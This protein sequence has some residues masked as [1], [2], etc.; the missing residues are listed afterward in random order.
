MPELGRPLHPTIGP[1]TSDRIPAETARAPHAPSDAGLQEGGAT[2]AS[3]LPDAMF[4]GI[5]SIADDAIVSIDEAFRIVFFNRGAERIFG[6]IAE[7]VLGRELDLLIPVSLREVHR[8]HIGAFSAS[9]VDAR[10][11]GERS[12]IFGLRRNGER[13]PAEA[14]ISKLDVGGR[15]IY[16]ALLRDISE[17]KRAEAERQQLLARE[18]EARSAAEAAERRA[19]F[20]AEASAVL[21]SSLDFEA[22]LRSL[23]GLLVPGYADMCVVDLVTGRGVVQRVEVAHADPTRRELADRLRAYPDAH[24]WY[25]T[26]DAIR[27]GKPVLVAEVTDAPWRAHTEDAEHAELLR[28]LGISSYVAVPLVAR[29]H[30]LGALALCQG[31]AAQPYGP[32]DLA[33]AVAFARAAAL[34]VDNARLYRMEQRA[35]QA[36]DEVLGVVTHDLRNPL[37]VLSMCASSLL[38]GQHGAET[39]VR[40]TAETIRDA[41]AWALRLIQDLLDVAMIEAGHLAL[42]RRPQDAVILISKAAVMFE[43]MAEERS[44]RLVLD[45][46][47]QLP[48]VEA[49]GERVLQVLSNLIGNALKFTPAGGEIRLGA[50]AGEGQ[51]RISVADTGTGIPAEQLLHVF[52]R[53]WHARRGASVRGTGLGLAIAKGIVEAHGGRLEVKSEPGRGSAFSFTLRVVPAADSTAMRRSPRPV[54]SQDSA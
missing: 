18:R 30:V 47:D 4:A 32:A 15:R 29:G 5:A 44:L 39:A 13:F 34:A 7:E 1:V 21:D 40:E 53:Y 24:S 20:L 37:S 25:I 2:A 35:V 27:T 31:D 14:S 6:Y 9:P 38:E 46:P 26:R 8:R 42:E 51:V 41:A 28:A 12:E 54:P 33:F 49:D 11:M 45:V 22:T 19:T 17:R 43:R 16:T 23:V 10:Q 50:E 48:Q 36:R 3:P 52:D